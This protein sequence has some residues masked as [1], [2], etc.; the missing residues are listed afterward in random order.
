MKSREVA[1]IGMVNCH[2]LDPAANSKITRQ[3]LKRHD[4]SRHDLVS[5]LIMQRPW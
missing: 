4:M 3:S 5:V 1:C 2:V